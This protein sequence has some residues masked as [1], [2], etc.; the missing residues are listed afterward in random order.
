M[1]DGNTEG[2]QPEDN[3][4][5]GQWTSNT[6]TIYQRTSIRRKNGGDR[7][8][9]DNR[10]GSITENNTEDNLPEDSTEDTWKTTKRPTFQRTRHQR[11]HKEQN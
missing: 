7:L 6:R 3:L 10:K 9:K 2:L 8:T 1:P 5:P 11:K 4:F